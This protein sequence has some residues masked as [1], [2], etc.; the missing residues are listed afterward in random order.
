MAVIFHEFQFLIVSCNTSDEETR[1]FQVYTKVR[2]KYVLRKY[3][4]LFH[5]D[6]F[7]FLLSF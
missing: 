3:L 4:A 2:I 5:M 6:A 1:P 7:S